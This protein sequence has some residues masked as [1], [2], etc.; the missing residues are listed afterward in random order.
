MEIDI[1][2]QEGNRQKQT[3]YLLV[4]KFSK[5]VSVYKEPMDIGTEGEIGRNR[6]VTC[7]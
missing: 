3:C 6:L 2:G 7:L 1:E 4:K 5:E